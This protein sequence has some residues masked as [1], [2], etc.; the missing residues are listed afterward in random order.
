MTEFRAEQ[1]RL[2]ES[3]MKHMEELMVRQSRQQLKDDDS[4]SRVDDLGGGLRRD[5]PPNKGDFN[6]RVEIPPFDNLDANGLLV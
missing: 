2:M 5:P 1:G 4:T 3:M 6:R